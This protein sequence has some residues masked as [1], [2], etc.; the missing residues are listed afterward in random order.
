MKVSRV[1]EVEVDRPLTDIYTEL[2]AYFKDG[3]VAREYYDG[4]L[5]SFMA[6]ADVG[7]E[8]SQFWLVDHG[9]GADG[10]VAIWWQEE[11][12][13]VKSKMIL[14]P[15]SGTANQKYVQELT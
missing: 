7:N 9:T 10:V 12:G 15:V 2:L 6:N 13:T 1:Y 8:A 3:S 11:P 4:L 5:D 14:G